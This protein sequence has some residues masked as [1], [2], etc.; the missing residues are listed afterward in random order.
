MASVTKNTI[1]PFNTYDFDTTLNFN[2]INNQLNAEYKEV[3]Q[4]Q[5]ESDEMK[6]FFLNE[7]PLCTRNIAKPCKMDEICDKNIL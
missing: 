4:N 1:S 7:E 2:P 3:F 5:Y 6:S